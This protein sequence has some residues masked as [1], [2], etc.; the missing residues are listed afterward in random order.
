MS[1]TPIPGLP[2]E[3]N[4]RLIEL[5]RKTKRETILQIVQTPGAA[6]SAPGIS[7]TENVSL[8]PAQVTD[9]AITLHA[10]PESF[11]NYEFALQQ[12]GYLI[13]WDTKI[14]ED[15]DCTFTGLRPETQ[16]YAKVRGLNTFGQSTAWS[17]TILILTEK[18]VVP[19]PV[20]E[21]LDLVADGYYVRCKV[22][23]IYLKNCP[24][25]DGFAFYV[26][27]QDGFDPSDENL[28]YI[29]RSNRFIFHTPDVGITYYVRVKSYDVNGNYS[30][31]CA[32]ESVKVPPPRIPPVPEDP[33]EVGELV[34]VE[35]TVELDD[36]DSYLT[37]ESEAPD[38][39]RISAAEEGQIKE[40]TGAL[41]VEIDKYARKINQPSH[42]NYV[43]IGDSTSDM[44]G[45]QRFKAPGSFN[46]K[47]ISIYVRKLGAPWPLY[48]YIYSDDNGDPDALLASTTVS[49]I[50]E[51]Y[52]WRHGD[53]A[54][55][56]AVVQ[57]NYYWLIFYCQ[58]EVGG[59]YY[60]ARVST[61]NPYEG[62][63][64]CYGDGGTVTLPNR[65]TNWDLA[66]KIFSDETSLNKHFKISSLGTKN[67]TDCPKIE[68]WAQGNSAANGSGLTFSMGEAGLGEQTGL[69]AVPSIYTPVWW[70]I[71]DI[72]NEDK[73]AIQHLGI[74]VTYA[75]DQ[76]AIFYIDYIRG[77]REKKVKV[78]FSDEVITIYPADAEKLQT[79]DISQ[80]APEDGQVL[81]WD[82]ANSRWIPADAAGGDWPPDYAVGPYVI[83]ASY[84]E[85]SDTTGGT[86]VKKKE[87]LIDRPGA[88]RV[89]FEIRSSQ[90]GQAV[91][92]R[93]Y[94]N[95]AAWGT[96]R[97]N[98]T[99]TYAGWDEDFSDYEVGDLIQLYVRS[100]G[101]TSVYCQNYYIKTD[102][103]SYHSIHGPLILNP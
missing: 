71:S 11:D 49:G 22:D 4:R 81:T 57:G 62:E 55:P 10:H 63:S 45:G 72:A 61:A 102:L 9:T 23:E 26:S 7:M 27:T 3:L 32:Q 53:F 36:C 94:K 48:A 21:G 88:I 38:A 15:P 82:E 78:K 8:G 34:I 28:K 64:C 90:A 83:T 54:S 12:S 85:E 41:K 101:T 56:P 25:F 46:L 39:I 92:G 103:A 35:G 87:I 70:D 50:T 6:R 65:Y 24:D 77:T 52:E 42:N 67:L 44:F 18:D 58:P 84:L 51:D 98:N 1:K 60:I 5:D 86:Y 100:F 91:Y 74:K 14:T 99:T 29:G 89:Y 37:W 73:D 66:F 69:V 97:V 79:R 47:R 43:A 17:D 19:P 80:L 20:P 40:G 75:Q 2:P 31:A 33:T 68:Y 16:Y 95:G 76:T 30:E 96:E 93:I 59:D 13:G